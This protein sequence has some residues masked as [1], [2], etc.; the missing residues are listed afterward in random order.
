MPTKAL[1]RVNLALH[2]EEINLG[3]VYMYTIS[4]VIIFYI[5]ARVEFMIVTKRLAAEPI[6]RLF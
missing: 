6:S 1:P 2:L 3:H 5:I 4:V